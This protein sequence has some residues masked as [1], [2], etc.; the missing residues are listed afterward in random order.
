VVDEP[1]NISAYIDDESG[2]LHAYIY[3]I[4]NG[5][6]EKEEMEHKNGSKIYYYS[7]KY[8]V[9]NYAFYIEAID[10]SANRNRNTTSK[11]FFEIP[12]DYDGDGVPDEIEVNI[13][14]DPKNRNDTIN[15][16]VDKW[17]GYLIF[18][19]KDNKYI[20]WSKI[21]NKTRDTSSKDVNGDGYLDILFDANGDGIYDHY[22]NKRD[23][24]INVYEETEKGKGN[25]MIW[26]LPPSILFIIVGL[27]FIILRRR[28]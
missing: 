18:V 3:I 4:H 21:D 7:R 25:E 5:I 2:I 10:N 1:V 27:I 6:E 24:S 8:G 17:I 28:Y 15:V 22:Y 23:G 26:I 9:G 11:Y 12:S 20:Y 13:G 14:G 19:Q 16:S